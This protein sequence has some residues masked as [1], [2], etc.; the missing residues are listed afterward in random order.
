MTGRPLPPEPPRRRGPATRLSS[1]PFASMGPPRRYVSTAAGGAGFPA[2]PA[3]FPCARGAGRDGGGGLFGAVPARAPRTA[4]AVVRAARRG[5]RRMPP[6]PILGR[7]RVFPA[8]CLPPSRA[9][10]GL[11]SAALPCRSRP[12]VRSSPVPQSA[13]CPPSSP[14]SPVPQPASCPPGFEEVTRIPQETRRRSPGYG[15]R[16]PDRGG[17]TM[18]GGRRWRRSSSGATPGCARGISP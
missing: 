6:C 14:F 18:R 4:A 13:S 3:A 9:A 11:A 7:P 10:A 17:R 12:R 1:G 2:P 8:P 15:R 16:G 5:L